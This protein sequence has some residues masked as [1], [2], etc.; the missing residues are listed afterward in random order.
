MVKA[1]LILIGRLLA[2]TP[3]FLL[4]PVVWL[5]GRLAWWLIASRRRLILSNLHHAFPERPAAWHAAIGRECFR[6]VVETAC[7]SMA[8]PFLPEARIRRML[9]GDAGLAKLFAEQQTR[10]HPVMVCTP[11]VAHW[12]AGTALR[13]VVDT[14]FPE[15]GVIFRPLDNAAADAWL[16]R[17]RERFGMKLLSRREGFLE[18]N[19]ILSRNGCVVILFD[20]NAGTQGA[21]TTLFGRVCSTTAMPGSLAARNGAEVVSIYPRHIGFWRIQLCCEPIRNDG[22]AEGITIALNQWLKIF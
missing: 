5:L 20:Q 3:E 16:K 10:P 15:F 13:L 18:A 8:M 19:H 4:R 9:T 22:T 14:P 17:T 2:W 21:L 6:R 11:H 12:E 1:G 7:F